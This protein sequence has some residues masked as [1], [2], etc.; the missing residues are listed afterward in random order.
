MRR[1]ASNALRE[2]STHFLDRNPPRAKSLVMTLF[3]DAIRPH[4][5]ALWLG[6]LIRLLAP[7]GINDR[8]V[9]TSVFRLA[10]DGWLSGQRE[11]RRSLYTLRDSAERRFTR[12]YKRVYSP[13]YLAWPGYWTLVFATAGTLNPQTRSELRKELTWEGFSALSPTVFVHPNPDRETL[14]E[15]LNAYGVRGDVFVSSMDQA[16][17][18]QCRPLSELVNEYWPLDE[19]S[20]NYHSFIEHFREL[21]AMMED[22]PSDLTPELA[23]VIRTL[24]IHEYRRALLHDPRLPIELLP[25]DWAGKT[26]YELCRDIYAATSRPAGQYIMEALREEDP[27]ATPAADFF[28]ERFG[29]LPR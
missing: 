12:A 25:D 28:Y 22:T 2:W 13:T 24:L 20:R 15:I 3:G 8:L 19:I 10:E 14:Q 7:F 4:G 6:S 21:P 5:G 27:N 11:G 9:R 18:I 16:P 1:E 26:A 23:F 29:G 17:D